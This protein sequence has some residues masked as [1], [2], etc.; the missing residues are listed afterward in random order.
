[1]AYRYGGCGAS[2]VTTQALCSSALG[3]TSGS[4]WLDVEVGR[5]DQ[6]TQR[7]LVSEIDISC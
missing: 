6:A 4:V 5:F 2:R 1:M 3:Q 7:I